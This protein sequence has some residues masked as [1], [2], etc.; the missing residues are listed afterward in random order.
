MEEEAALLMQHGADL[1]I[2]DADGVR[3]VTH[4]KATNVGDGVRMG[5]WSPAFHSL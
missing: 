3:V 2:P 4:P 1:N 5:W